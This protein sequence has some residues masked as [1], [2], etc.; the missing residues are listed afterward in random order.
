MIVACRGTR[1][2][3]VTILSVALDLSGDGNQSMIGDIFASPTMV[4]RMDSNG[5]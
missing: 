2:F 4:K 3:S 5:K 1:E